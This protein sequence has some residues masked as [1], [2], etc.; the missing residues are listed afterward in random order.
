VIAPLVLRG[1]PPLTLSAVG[2]EVEI[3]IS[4]SLG[5]PPLQV[6]RT[7][8]VVTPGLLSLC[9]A[10][11]PLRVG[12]DVALSADRAALVQAWLDSLDAGA[13]P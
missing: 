3:E 6:A 12:I 2:S 8:L 11:F 13:Y 4:G 7:Q 10:R 9:I 1:M 5:L